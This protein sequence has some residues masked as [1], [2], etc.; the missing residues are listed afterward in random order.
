MWKLHNTSNW[1]LSALSIYIAEIYRAFQKL[2]LR[3]KD[4]YDWD[5]FW[6]QIFKGERELIL[7]L[8][9]DLAFQGFVTIGYSLDV[10]QNLHAELFDLSVEDLTHSL[11]LLPALELLVKERGAV[12]IQL[13][14]RLGWQKFLPKYDYKI[15]NI[16]YEKEL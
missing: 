14:G 6:L 9:Q 1:D 7:L 5:R 11:R 10:K 13:W 3:F 4:Q 12:S 16:K 15:T 8:D 2:E